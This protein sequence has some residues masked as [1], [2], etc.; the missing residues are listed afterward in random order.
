MTNGGSGEIRLRL[1]TNTALTLQLMGDSDRTISL[2]PAEGGMSDLVIGSARDNETVYRSERGSIAGSRR[3]I[4][5][6]ELEEDSIESYP[7]YRSTRESIRRQP[8]VRRR[9]DDE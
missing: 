3:M 1:D 4:T 5:A 7:S 9:Q 8:L 6:R 2:N